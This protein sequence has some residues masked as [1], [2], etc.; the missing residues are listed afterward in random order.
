MKPFGKFNFQTHHKAFIALTTVFLLMF[1]SI[2]EADSLLFRG[3]PEIP[4]IALTFDDGGVPE[5]V[6]SVLKTLKKYNVHATFFFTGAFIEGNPAL[7]QQLAQEGHE[8]ANHSYAHPN[9]TKISRQ[10]VLNEL[11]NSAAAFQKASGQQ[12]KP[13]IRPPYGAYNAS[14]R[15]TITDAGYTHTVL[16]NIDTNDWRGKSSSQLVNHVLNHASNG[17]IV[18]MHTTKNSRAYQ[19]LP[20]MIE[21]L[22]KKGYQLV[23]I[24][25]II[26]ST[27]EQ[28]PPLGPEEISEVEFLNNLMAIRTG[29]YSAS[30]AEIREKA[31]Q[32]KIIDQNKMIFTKKA[33][34]KD[35]ILGYLRAAYPNNKK[36]ESYFKKLEFK[37]SSLS[38]IFKQIERIEQA[39]SR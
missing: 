20:A 11:N 33:L 22:Q 27:E 36:I 8:M 1:S 26:A 37:R 14:V 6:Q 39:E 35:E 25:E 29:S 21:G 38:E 19:A 17:S 4:Y 12:M 5:N 34:S 23:T 3:N 13:Y 9:F 10:R 16:W 31:I 2:C 32:Y 30:I 18:L 28:M 7:M 24:S 15:K